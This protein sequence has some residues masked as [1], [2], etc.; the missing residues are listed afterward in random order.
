MAEPAIT[1]KAAN[2]DEVANT[3]VTR[4]VFHATAGGRGFPHESESGVAKNT[5]SYFAKKTTQAS[6]HYVFDVENEEH[7][8]PE[9]R[10]AWHAPPNH[11]SVG[12]EICAEATYT[13][14]QWLSP[15]VW[16]AVE[17]AA[18]RAR[19]IAARHNVPLIK[20]SA[21]ELKAGAH[22][23]CGHVDVSTAFHESSHTDPGPGFPWDKLAELLGA[24][25][26]GTPAVTPPARS[27]TI[28]VNPPPNTAANRP[29][30]RSLPEWPLKGSDYFGS[31]TGPKASHG[32]WFG[33]EQPYVRLLQQWLIFH[34]VTSVDPG[35][36]NTSSWADG[37][38]EAETV[39]AIKLWHDRFYPNQKFT[40]RIYADDAA[41]LGRA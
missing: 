16:P 27:T 31:I 22:G 4:I 2:Y 23:Y 36:C 25:S 28:V 9:N 7:C 6:A 14:E 10:V 33:W 21:A 29:T 32:G 18:E 24:P 35:R 5:A 19:D 11:A 34:G 38:L 3:P 41:R 1:R 12:I 37:K 13:R 40:D 20:R 15:E 26:G 8:V 30:P 17:L 39:A